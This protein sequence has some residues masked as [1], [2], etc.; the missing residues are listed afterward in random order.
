MILRYHNGINWLTPLL[1]KM[2]PLLLLKMEAPQLGESPFLEV[3]SEWR[4]V[5]LHSLNM[6]LFCGFMQLWFDL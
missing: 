2:P 3:R 5:V 1:S 6:Y 4:C